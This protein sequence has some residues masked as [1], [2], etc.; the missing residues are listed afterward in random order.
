MEVALPHKML[1]L[2]TLRT[3][4]DRRLERYGNMVICGGKGGRG[5]R[6]VLE[7]TLDFYKFNFHFFTSDQQCIEGIQCP[8]NT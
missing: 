2:L 8:L 3:H 4:I 7:L 6:G 1:T 5:P